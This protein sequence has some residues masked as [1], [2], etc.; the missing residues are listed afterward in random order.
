MLLASLADLHLR[1]GEHGEAERLLVAAAELSDRVGTPPWAEVAIERTRGEVLLRRG[2]FVGAA[3]VA[4]AALDRADLSLAAQARMWNLL[5]IA[6]MS[7]GDLEESRAAF[8]QELAVYTALDL[9]T[10][11]A[12]S[13]GN[14]A[15]VML[16]LGDTRAA[17]AR[18]LASLEAAL[19]MGQPIMVAFSAVVAAHLAARLGMWGTAVRL[20]SAAES[21][22]AGAGVSLYPSDAEALEQLRTDA[23]EHVTPDELAVEH[24]AG[25][26]LDTVATADL[27]RQVLE[28]VVAEGTDAPGRVPA[29]HGGEAR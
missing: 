3:D 16:R 4:R 28:R 20:H 22:L 13:N 10:K 18:Q 2:D 19:V 25:A 17:A 5:G 15:E 1:R 6:S 29:I 14:V 23:T 24:D 8:L 21:E 27:A 12:S 26:G 7:D 9:D 11:A